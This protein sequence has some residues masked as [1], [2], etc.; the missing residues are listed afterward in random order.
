MALGVQL[1]TLLAIDIGNTHIKLGLRQNGQWTHDWRM[2]TDVRRTADEYRQPLKGFLAEA[3][4]DVVDNV[5]LA[6]VVPMLT[7]AFVRVGEALSEGRVLE[8]APPGYGM[9]V[10]Y[11][12]P[13]SLG[14]DRF[15]NAIAAYA[16]VG[17][18]VVV[19]DVG[20][21][22]TVDAVSQSGRF[23][24]GAIA[25]GPHF[26][27]QALAE[28][29]AR[30]PLIP[31]S[32][33]D[34]VL[35]R[36]TGEAIQVGVAQ[37]LIG[38]VDRLVRR[39][40]GLLGEE[41]PVVLTGGWGARLEPHLEFPVRLVPRLTLEGLARCADYAHLGGRVDPLA[42]RVEPLAKGGA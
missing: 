30:L 21:T 22:T 10:A 13:E 2:S 19:V 17:R 15:V 16:L 40:W 31:P 29:T 23:V 27:A 39:T 32:L 18:A 20:T 24:G 38:S 5:V 37:T 41:C 12:P 34:G 3:G 11:S 7:P 25:P 33:S 9:E 6:S 35:G 26:M 8:V 1:E 4:F 14:A 28:G 36:E 42:H